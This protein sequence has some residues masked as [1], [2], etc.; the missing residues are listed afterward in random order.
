[1]E[2]VVENVSCMLQDVANNIFPE[3]FHVTIDNANNHDDG[4]IPT[5]DLKV[6]V[7][8]DN[9]ILHQFYTKPVSFKGLVWSSSGL[10]IRINEEA[11]SD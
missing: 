4:K 10:Y 3:M 1:M 8:K 2:I 11:D 6:W 5:L 9:Q 7:S